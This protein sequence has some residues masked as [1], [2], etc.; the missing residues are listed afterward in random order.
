[1]T[2][3]VT[4]AAVQMAVRI[5]EKEAN[6]ARI[7]GRTREAARRGAVLAVFPECAVTGY[8]FDDPAEARSLAEPIPGPSTAALSR[9][10]RESEIWIVA[11]LVEAAGDG[12]HN[13]A[14]LIGPDGSIETY[15]KAHLPRIGLDRFAVPGGGPFRVHQTPIGRIGLQICYDAG[16]PEPSRVQALLGAD[17]IVLPTSWPA[18]AEELA[19][20]V[21]SARALENHLFFVAADRVGEERGARFIGRSRIVDPLGRTLAVAGS[22]AEEVLT[23]PIEPARARTKRVVRVPGKNEIDR[24]GDRRPELY[25]PIADRPVTGGG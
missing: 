13:S 9:A 2:D 16:F 3:T 5:G 18:G 22:D 25:G 12:F 21:P 6:V 8:A 20:H 14:A 11:G 17:I 7:A 10:A 1:M 24:I 19:E 23:A 15:R 4:I